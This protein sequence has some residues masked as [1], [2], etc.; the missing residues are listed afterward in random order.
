MYITK[1]LYSRYAEYI[2]ISDMKFFHYLIELAK[3]SFETHKEEF[4]EMTT[5]DIDALKKDRSIV[6]FAST[7]SNFSDDDLI[8][9]R[10]EMNERARRKYLI[11]D[12]DFDSGEELEA[13][14]MIDDLK[15]LSID[16]STPLIIY[17]TVSYPNKPRFRAV[18][19]VKKALNESSYHQAMTWLYKML[20]REPL[21][22]SDLKIRSNNNAPLFINQEQI[23]VVFDNTTDSELQPLDNVLWKNYPKPRLKTSRSIPKSYFDEFKIPED[24]LKEAC[25]E[26]A[27]SD[28]ARNFNTF[29]FVFHS[30]A[31]AEYFEQITPELA[32]KAL[33]WI[34]RVPGDPVNAARWSIENKNQYK[35]ERRR[36]FENEKILLNARPLSKIPEFGNV[37]KLHIA[38]SIN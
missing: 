18:L 5:S 20:G 26:F 7:V 17:P 35:N 33:E 12:A 16:F 19:F 1:N 28:S 27:K 32:R 9:S 13:S 2:N 4:L 15:Q 23:D 11:I 31:R 34:A 25:L 30:I 6:L 21:D 29:W 14:Q 24:L 8:I 38:E 36:V 22:A 3:E 10:P 37:F